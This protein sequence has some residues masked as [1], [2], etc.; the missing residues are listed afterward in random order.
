MWLLLVGSDSEKAQLLSPHCHKILYP[1]LWTFTLLYRRLKSTFCVK[2]DKVSNATCQL[3]T[4]KR[5]A[6]SSSHPLFSCRES[7]QIRKILPNQGSGQGLCLCFPLSC[8][9][10]QKLRMSHNSNKPF[11][12]RHPR[13]KVKCVCLLSSFCW[14]RF[15]YAYCSGA[16]ERLQIFSNFLKIELK[17][18]PSKSTLYK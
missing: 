11:A 1:S 3:C 8:L 13:E 12:G 9:G 7:C 10:T 17:Y 2:R 4:L 5:A 14:K 6:F 15:K 18:V 16:S